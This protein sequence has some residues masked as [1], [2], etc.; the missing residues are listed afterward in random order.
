MSRHTRIIEVYRRY[1]HD[2]IIS[3]L[4]MLL[5]VFFVLVTRLGWMLLF[6]RIART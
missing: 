3:V 2:L 4:V 6:R 1:H 5:L